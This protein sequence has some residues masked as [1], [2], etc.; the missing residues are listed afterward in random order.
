[1][2]LRPA[3]GGHA[4]IPQATRL[5]FRNLSSLEH[6]RVEGLI[7][8]GDRVLKPGLP[9][10]RSKGGSVPVDQQLNQLGRVVIS[11]E[12]G[13][14]YSPVHATIHAIAM[15]VKHL[16]GGKQTLTRFD[17]IHFQDFVWR[18]FF[19]NTL[20]PED[21]AT[22]MRAAFRIARVPWNA[23]HICAL[24]TRKIGYP[25]YPRLDTADFDVMIT[26][27]PYPATVSKNTTLVVRYHDAIPLL[28]PH[29][30]SSRRFHHAFHYRALRKNVESGAWFACVSD[31]TRKDLISI[32]PKAEERS[33]TI[34]NSVS[35]DYFTEDS[36][37]SR[38]TEII[39]ARLNGNPELVM[40]RTLKRKLFG[41]A[42]K[43]ERLKYL[44]I[45]STVEP[46]KNH[47]SLMTAWERLRFDRHPNLKL[48]IVGALGWHHG[49]ILQ[50]FRPWLERAECFLLEN[51]LASELRALHR[52]AQATVC[53]SFNE[54][55][56]F[57]GVEAMR[58]GGAVVA[59]D[60]PVHR[61]IFADAAEYFNPY[62]VEELAH[63]IQAVIDPERKMRR[64]ELV[65]RGAI[66]SA[67][68][69]HERITSRWSSFLA[70][71]AVAGR[72]ATCPEIEDESRNG[73]A[74]SHASIPIALPELPVGTRRSHNV[75]G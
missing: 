41:D 40:D 62:S 61:E 31:A 57:S 50:R 59:S 63:A 30:I 67:R 54:G 5:L 16:F 58:S 47:L 52:H 34:H 42:Q 45:V 15:A 36:I 11:I 37:P 73:A 69:T 75:V 25:L 10:H 51:V 21:F 14:R 55:F 72:D 33:V 28:M 18:R 43:G 68:Y 3:L 29:T 70:A 17:S 32:F 19:A 66:I 44:L 74:T 22:V 20:P 71:P 56:D 48:V 39:R 49:G 13:N 6:M 26:E 23:M 65:A 7:Q 8:S 12:Q 53:P 9:P 27:T 64:D 2:E 60:I 38:V 35:P 46:R 1:M 24:V 4:G